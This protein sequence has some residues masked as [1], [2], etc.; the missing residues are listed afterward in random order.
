MVRCILCKKVVHKTIAT[1]VRD[2]KARVFYCNTCQLGILDHIPTEYKLKKYYEKEYRKTTSQKLGTGMDPQGLFDMAVDF[3][4]NRIRLLKKYL[5]KDKKLLDVGCSVGMFLWHAKKYV[6]EAVGLDYDSNS[7]KFAAKKCGC[8]TYDQD[9]EKTDLKKNYFDIICAFQTLEHVGNP[10]EFIST[11]K[12]YLKPG[13]VMAIEVPNL[14][15]P[16]LYLYDIPYYKKFFF[17]KSHLWYFTHTSLEKLMAKQGFGGTTFFIQ[18]Y[19]IMNHMNWMLKNEPQSTNLP[20]LKKPVL[21]FNNEVSPN[22]KKEMSGFIQHVDEEYR[23]QL[24]KLKTSSIIMYIGRL[25]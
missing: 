6:K 3:Q 18:D 14:R 11:Y 10:L 8:K 12:K 1:E 15:D 17:H 25:K 13:G 7:A 20:G 22:I 9:I 5:K 19:N 21:S 23:N 2:G 4:E 16:L 24:I